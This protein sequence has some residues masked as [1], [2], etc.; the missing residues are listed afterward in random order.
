[1]SGP[2]MW[3]D[4][5]NVLSPILLFIVV[6]LKYAVQLAAGAFRPLQ[7]VTADVHGCLF[8]HWAQ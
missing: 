4:Q 5:G 6:L 8:V 7:G 1:M 3:S 2:Q